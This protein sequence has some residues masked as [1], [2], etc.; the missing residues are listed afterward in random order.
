M[1]SKETTLAD[2]TDR[3][4][5]HIVPELGHL[6]VR[7]LERGRVHERLGEVLGVR[8][9]DF[10]W[11]A[12][13]VRL[14][15]AITPK[16]KLTTL[17]TKAA[18][19]VELGQVLLETLRQHRAM[20]EADA[21]SRG[22]GWTRPANYGP[23]GKG[24]TREGCG[25][26]SR[27]KRTWP[28]IAVLGAL[29]L[30][31]SRANPPEAKLMTVA[32]EDTDTTRLAHAVLPAV[33]AHPGLA[34]IHALPDPRGAFAA[35]ALLAAAAERT[36]DAQ[37]YIW[38]GDE[39]GTLLFEAL[40]RA[41]GRGVRVRLLVDDNNTAGLDDTLAA[42]D[43]HPKIEVRLYNALTRRRVRALNYVT[44]FRR[45]NRRMHNKSFTVD[46]Q[47]TVVGGRNVGDEYFGAGDGM[48]FTDLDVLAVGP[49]VREVSAEF[50]LYWNSES[51]V[52]AAGLL[53]PAGA[54]EVRRLE[55]RFAS[56]RADREAERY[57]LA[58]RETTLVT[59]LL[60]GRLALEWT[61]ARVVCDDPRKTLDTQHRDDLLLLPRMLV[62]VGRPA[63]RLDL[64]S[65]YF[66]PMAEGTAS[67][68][69]LSAAPIEAGLPVEELCRR[70]SKLLFQRTPP[71]KYATSF[72]ATV[73]LTSGRLRYTNAGHNA[74]LA[75]RAGGEIER[76]TSTGVPLG[77]LP[78][79]PFTAREIDLAPGDLV[80]VYTDGIV[81]AF[82]P[83][84]EEFGLERLEAICREHRAVPLGELSNVIDRELE[85][86]VRGVPF[87]DD[88]TLVLLRREPG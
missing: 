16:G 75:V 65:P 25:T 70:V 50:D 49:V 60:G 54:E 84:D 43:A 45:L 2:Y 61:G 18:R 35:R 88:R 41:A 64:V 34:G 52:P 47:A 27:M 62:L 81:E 24:E 30:G 4:R 63:T 53:R 14:E 76:L 59:E 12:K 19:T 1:R 31:C 9:S 17:K 57:L 26:L 5:L 37:Y 68:E 73:E 51:A 10:D 87:P 36:I 7:A 20:L 11:Q 13:T 77:M 82:D 48:V 79:A 40:W 39:T 67:L 28:W 85:K 29:A 72:V 3:V 8:W 32:A 42:L 21:L 80:V 23:L 86:F 66:V 38:H 56:V 15:R 83:S 46:N 6:K 22:I 44:D 33:A 71:A 55:S 69:A 78:E 74:G 58:L